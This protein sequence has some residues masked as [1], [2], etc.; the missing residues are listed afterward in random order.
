[1][2][3]P[4]LDKALAMLRDV[5]APCSCGGVHLADGYARDLVCDILSEHDAEEDDD[6]ASL[7]TAD[8]G[9]LF[10]TLVLDE[11]YDVEE[12][13]AIYYAAMVVIEG[14]DR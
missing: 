4:T 13:A 9:D 11:R 7:T 6:V 10:R 5:S 8:A 2:S 3:R 14:A 1:M 12:A